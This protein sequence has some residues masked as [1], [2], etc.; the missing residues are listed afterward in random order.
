MSAIIFY[1][2]QP[3]TAASILH[4]QLLSEIAS[5]VQYNLSGEKVFINLR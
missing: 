4:T 5:E 1:A 2:I 3:F